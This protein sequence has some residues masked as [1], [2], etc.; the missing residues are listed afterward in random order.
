MILQRVWV[1]DLD[2]Y[3]LNVFSPVEY[4][5]EADLCRAQARYE[6]AESLF[7]QSLAVAEKKWGPE[8]PNL[9]TALY[10]LAQLYRTQ[11]R[12]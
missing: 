1:T 10:K 4:H 6:E 5:S 8:H 11:G 12:N 9:A 3:E 2:Q 7:L